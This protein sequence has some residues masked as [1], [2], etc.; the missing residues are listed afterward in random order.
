MA[1]ETSPCDRQSIY[2]ALATER[3]YEV[4]G[5]LTLSRL[6]QYIFKITQRTESNF[7]DCP[8]KNAMKSKRT[9]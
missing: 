5:K 1:A 3:Q 2:D 6:I 4:G 9:M 8:R 7:L